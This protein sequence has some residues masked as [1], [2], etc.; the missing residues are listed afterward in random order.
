MTK[1]DHSNRERAIAGTLLVSERDM[2]R[3]LTKVVKRTTADF[4]ASVHSSTVAHLHSVIRD[5]MAGLADEAEGALADERAS[6]R[7][8]SRDQHQKA[9]GSVLVLATGSK[10]EAKSIERQAS[11]AIAQM[12][13]ATFAEV[14]AMDGVRARVAAHHLANSWANSVLRSVPKP[15]PSQGPYRTAGTRADYETV[16]KV[17]KNVPT[18]LEPGI[19]RIAVTEAAEAHNAEAKR[20]YEALHADV[21]DIISIEWSAVLDKRTCDACES[22]HGH[23]V[24]SDYPPLHAQCRCVAVPVRRYAARRAAA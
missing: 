12:D 2:Q 3:A 16:A 7:L 5:S 8:T 15:A 14:I 24:D 22:R 11:Q 6:A 17:T 20:L 1:P 13:A 21:R 23:R 4:V 9:L 18:D 10:T 19:R